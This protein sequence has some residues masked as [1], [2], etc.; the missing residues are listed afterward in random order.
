LPKTPGW[1]VGIPSNPKTP[2]PAPPEVSLLTNDN[3]LR[4]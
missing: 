4:T 3:N 2:L 1:G